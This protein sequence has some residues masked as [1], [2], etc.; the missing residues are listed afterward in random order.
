LILINCA[1][2]LAYYHTEEGKFLS[3]DPIGD[4]GGDNLY[5]FVNNDPVNMIDIFGLW[6]ETVHRIR[7]TTWAIQLNYKIVAAHNIGDENNSVD[8]YLG[9]ITH[10][11]QH[12][13]R[14]G[15]VDSR[16]LHYTDH[17]RNAKN[18]CTQSN[19]KPEEAVKELGKALH[20]LQDWVAHGDFSGNNV[21][22]SRSPQTEPW[23]YPD[24]PNL[25]SDGPNGRAVGS[26]MHTDQNAEYAIFH[27]GN[28]RITY[29]EAITKRALIEFYNHVKQHGSCKCRQYFLLEDLFK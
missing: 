13:N 6:D 3:R 12:F 22:N 21:H 4:N 14:G 1:A 24:D 28:L 25:D 16:M 9:Y 15:G 11:G 20:P 5:V 26:A 10:P 17:L 23:R 19:D 8:A 7:T 29:T 2:A 18:D 27:P